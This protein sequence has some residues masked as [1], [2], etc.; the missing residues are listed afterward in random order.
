MSYPI[1]KNLITGLPKDPY[2]HGIGAYE[3]VVAHSTA[4]PNATAASERTFESSHYNSAFVHFFVDWT[5]IV[6]V[7]DTD[8]LAYGA[9]PNANHRFVNVELCETSD[10]ALFAQAYA[11]YTWLLAKI[12][13]DRKLGVS[14]K[15]TFWTHDDVRQVLGGTTHSDPV[16]FLASHGV[17]IDKLVADVTAKYG[18]LA[19]PAPA[20]GRYVKIVNVSANAIMMDR[21]DRVA[22]KNISLIPKGTVVSMLTPLDGVNNPGVGYYKVV[23]NGKTGYINAKFG[24]KI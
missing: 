3:G 4:T 19:N 12:L 6:Q 20:P 7:A 9:G 2:R 17:S 24:Q 22:G 13:F 21:P 1:T 5:S 23:Y 18:L 14:R 15:N 16:A 8:Y 10:P 11:R